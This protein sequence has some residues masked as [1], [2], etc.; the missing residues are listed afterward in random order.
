MSNHFGLSIAMPLPKHPKSR[1][2]DEEFSRMAR[3]RDSSNRDTGTWML[4]LLSRLDADFPN[5]ELWG[6]VN[7]GHLLLRAPLT[8]SASLLILGVPVMPKR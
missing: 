1:P 3:S 7:H 5:I 8:R 6:F 4:E 2:L